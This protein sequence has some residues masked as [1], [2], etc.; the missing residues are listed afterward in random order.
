MDVRVCN[1]HTFGSPELAMYVMEAL[2]DRSACLMANHGMV[3]TGTGL[4]QAMWRAGELEAIA[5]Q[6]HLA[7]LL[8]DPHILGKEEIDE[9]FKMFA[10]YGVQD[11]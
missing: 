7:M 1:Y 4:E 9:T 3:A 8:G 2:E 6:Y 11:G 10:G 5:Q